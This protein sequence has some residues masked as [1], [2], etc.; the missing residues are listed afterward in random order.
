[1][2]II[3]FNPIL[4]YILYLYSQYYLGYTSSKG[5]YLFFLFF[6]LTV[7]N[8]LFNLCSI[9]SILIYPFLFLAYYVDEE[10]GEIPDLC[11]LWIIFISILFHKTHFIYSISLLCIGGILSYLNLIGFGD[12]KLYSSL[13]FMIGKPIILVIIGSS[14]IGLIYY[15][16]KKK[17]CMFPFAPSIIISF[18]LVEYY[19]SLVVI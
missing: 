15:L 12:I 11:H 3:L 7:I 13:C 18:I 1:M 14:Y 6:L 8:T 17:E 2:N 4:L 19:L 5:I 9:D 10:C 16:I